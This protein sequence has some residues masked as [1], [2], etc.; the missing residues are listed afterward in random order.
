MSQPESPISIFKIRR[1][2]ESLLLQEARLDFGISYLDDALLGM[3]PKELILVGAR[4]GGGKTEF[5][6]QVLLTQSARSKSVLY[7]ALDHEPNEIQ[8]RI[9]FRTLARKIRKDDIPEFRGVHFR[10]AS[11]RAGRF[12][13]SLARCFSDR[14]LSMQHAFDLGDSR[15]IYGKGKFTGEEVA[16]IIEETGSRMEYRLFII[17]H[18][19]ALKFG[20]NTSAAQSRAIRAISAAAEKAEVPVLLMGQFR[21]RSPNS[22]SPIPDMDEFSGHSDQI[23]IPQTIIVFGPKVNKDSHQFQTYF[24]VVKA[25]AAGDAKPFV[26]IHGFDIGLNSYSEKYFMARHIPFSEPQVIERPLDMP[27]WSKNAMKPVIYASEA[28]Y[29]LKDRK[30]WE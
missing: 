1:E 16:K 21:K 15:F 20:D 8:N 7:I 19:H 6:T 24:H 29:D 10:Y 5:A 12:T 2:T 13:E 26:G 22:K 28:A 11:W 4:S 14:E 30:D 3:F 25:R 18:F 27:R 9:L 23:Y 17:D